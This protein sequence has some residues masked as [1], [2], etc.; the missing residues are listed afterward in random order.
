MLE[1]FN[2][3][4]GMIGDKHVAWCDMPDG[5]YI[6]PER[7]TEQEAIADR[8]NLAALAEAYMKNRI[9]NAIITRAR[10]Q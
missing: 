6:G 7:D 1:V 8:D 3:G 9:P 5:R 4:I 10:L 2:M